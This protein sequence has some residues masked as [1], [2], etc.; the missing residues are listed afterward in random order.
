MPTKPINYGNRKPEAFITK[1]NIIKSSVY[2]SGDPIDFKPGALYYIEQDD[3]DESC[4]LRLVEY[5]EEVIPTPDY[6]KLI[7]KWEANESEF[8]KRLAT[9]Y[10]ELAIY[11]KQ[12][13]AEMRDNRLALYHTLK[14]EFEA[15][16]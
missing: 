8:Q 3:D 13:D 10:D 15:K 9:Y 12:K 16:K 2:W 6:D 1:R 14:A 7:I 4:T 5:T 11:N